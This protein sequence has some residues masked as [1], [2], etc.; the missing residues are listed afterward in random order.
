MLVDKTPA[1]YAAIVI[2]PVIK[3]KYFE[4]TW[5]DA[6]TQKDA[7][8]PKTQLPSKQAALSSIWKDYK[9]LLVNDDI[10]TSGS[11]RARSPDRH[12]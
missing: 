9:D 10:P 12:E 2:N 3:Q 5:K 7:T 8:N 11:K 4:Y 6:T 1:Y